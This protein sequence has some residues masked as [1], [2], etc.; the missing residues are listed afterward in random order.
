MTTDIRF[1]LGYVKDLLQAEILSGDDFLNRL[2]DKFAATDFM[3]AVLAFSQPGALLLT[4]LVN[5]QV[6]NTAEVAALSGVVFVGGVRP[7]PAVI[8]KAQGLDLPTFL[9]PN[10]LEQASRVLADRGLPAI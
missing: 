9:S 8:N 4:R 6:V 7:P 5:V 1:T 3:S 2:V 10:T